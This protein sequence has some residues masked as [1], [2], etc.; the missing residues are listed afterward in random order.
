MGVSDKDSLYGNSNREAY[1][2]MN[3]NGLLYADVNEIQKNL[4]QNHILNEYSY[5]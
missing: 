3:K 4:N 1:V 5:S 2:Y